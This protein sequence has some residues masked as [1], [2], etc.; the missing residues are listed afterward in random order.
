MSIASFL[1]K[2][3]FPVCLSATLFCQPAPTRALTLSL[4][5]AAPAPGASDIYNFAGADMDMNNIFAAGNAPTTNGAAND[6][7]TYVA[8]DR[9]TQGQTF[10]TGSSPG[11]YLLSDVWVEHAGYTDNTVDPQTAGSN[12]TW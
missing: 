3:A 5:S 6:A 8:N 12:G 1:T 7:Y 9:A 11:G 2:R 10:T 4:G